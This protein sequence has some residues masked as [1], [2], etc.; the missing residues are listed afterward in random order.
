[1]RDRTSRAIVAVAF[2]LMAS[3]IMTGFP[4][5]AERQDTPEHSV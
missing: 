2:A 3:M 1:M 4:Q 5:T